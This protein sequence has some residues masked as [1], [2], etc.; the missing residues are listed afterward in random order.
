MRTLLAALVVVTATR[1]AHADLIP[2][3]LTVEAHGS[4][5]QI[6]L[7]NAGGQPI[8]IPT[9]SP[10]FDDHLI[11]TLEAD[12]KSPLTFAFNEPSDKP[13]DR[14]ISLAPGASHAETIDLASWVF[15]GNGEP[16]PPGDYKVWLEWDVAKPLRLKGAARARTTM[17]IPAPVEGPCAA[18]P[19]A[20]GIELFGRALDQAGD[21]EIGLHNTSSDVICVDD[22]VIAANVQNDWLAIDLADN[23]DKKAAVRFIAARN[24][25]AVVT[26]KLAP[27]ATTW[28]RWNL[29][30]WAKRDNVALVHGLVY[31]KATYDSS[32][33]TAVVFRGIATAS[34]ALWLP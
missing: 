31:A 22:R 28:T 7:T 18:K 21:I 6:T 15:H 11:V 24:E 1:S 8:A 13:I 30:A 27:G 3:R 19:A 26:V 34:F 10:G 14:T 2:I 33:E 16:P 5:L 25:S 20:S 29:V 9:N 4:T 32:R 12:G 17:T 23:H